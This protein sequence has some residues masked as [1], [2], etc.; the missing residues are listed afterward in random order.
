MGG[1]PGGEKTLSPLSASVPDRSH[2][3]RPPPRRCLPR[4]SL[5]PPPS[6]RSGSPPPPPAP[7]RPRRRQRDRARFLLCPTRR[8]PYPARAP[9]PRLSEERLPAMKG[10]SRPPYF[11]LLFSPSRHTASSE[12]PE[13]SPLTYALP[14]VSITSAPSNKPGCPR[15][16]SLLSRPVPFTSLVIRLLSVPTFSSF[17]GHRNAF[18]TSVSGHAPLLH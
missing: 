2:L 8:P 13:L 11:P 14:T 10:L 4:R 6:S 18:K 5:A 17:P 15:N 9:Q 1:P 3:L 12:L 16:M 7:P